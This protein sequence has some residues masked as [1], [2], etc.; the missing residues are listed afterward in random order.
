MVQGRI[1]PFVPVADELM[2]GPVDV[3]DALVDLA[4]IAD[5][6]VDD[7]AV[8]LLGDPGAKVLVVLQKKRGDRMSLKADGRL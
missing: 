7:G 2:D 5:V 6:D 3:M 4:G 8:D 1:F